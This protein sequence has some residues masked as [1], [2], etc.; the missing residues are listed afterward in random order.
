MHKDLAVILTPG[1]LDQA[2]FSILR[3]LRAHG[4]FYIKDQRLVRIITTS[5]TVHLKEV[6]SV[7][8]AT[9]LSQNMKFLKKD[10]TGKTHQLDCPEALCR[11]FLSLGNWELPQLK[12]IICAPTIKPN[13]ELLIKE[14][15]DEESGLYM[16]KNKDFV[17]FNMAP[18]PTLEDAK[19]A[20]FALCDLIRDFPFRDPPSRSVALS[21]VLTGLVR[22]SLPTAPLHAFTAPKMGTGKSLLAAVVSLIVTGHETSVIS[23]STNESE[24]SKRLLAVLQDGHPIVCIDNIERPFGSSTLCSILTETSYKGRVLGKTQTAIYPTSILFLATGNN[25]V[26]Q[27][28]ISTRVVLSSLDAEVQRPEEREFA[29]NLHHFIPQH[30]GILVQYAL[31]ILHAYNQAGRPKQVFKPFGRFEEWS[32]W[33]RSALVWCGMA[34]PC[35]SRKQLEDDDPVRIT[36]AKTLEA[37]FKLVGN[38]DFRIRDVYNKAVMECNELILECFSE[39]S[40][41]PTKNA[42][43]CLKKVGQYFRAN[44]RRIEGGYRAIRCGSYQNADT[45]RVEKI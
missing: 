29:V 43:I 30:R 18:H 24:E 4:S 13:G 5:E 7:Y 31:T 17:F 1:E 35:A 41:T 11:S 37:W 27:G 32:N 44:N 21:A 19:E 28:D 10:K 16:H 12:N 9:F 14:G 33:I 42:N 8:L 23:Q 40:N 34:D 26:F 38:L 15:F 39:I 36:L 20:A 2:F 22:S 3:C 6:D 45:W 25:L